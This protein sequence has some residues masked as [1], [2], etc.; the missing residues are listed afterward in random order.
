MTSNE[1]IIVG[2]T[3]VIAASAVAMIIISK[4]YETTKNQVLS[5]IKDIRYT[6]SKTR[7]DIIVGNREIVEGNNLLREIVK[8]DIGNKIANKKV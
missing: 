1:K 5:D 4:E 3:I 8:Q 6:I 2:S 7:E